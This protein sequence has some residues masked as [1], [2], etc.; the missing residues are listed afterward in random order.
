MSTLR[1]GR[2][3]SSTAKAIRE[4]RALQRQAQLKRE[5][6]NV[7]KESAVTADLAD[8]QSQLNQKRKAIAKARL[9]QLGT[10][11]PDVRAIRQSRVIKLNIE[12]QAIQERINALKAEQKLASRADRLRK[13]L[14]RN[15][16]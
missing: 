7:R 6:R 13:E 8:A 3:K 10:L 9:S 4:G 5:I 12:M 11:S 1:F 14:A 16:G 15:G 2:P